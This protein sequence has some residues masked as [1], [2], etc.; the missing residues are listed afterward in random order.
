[1]D[2]HAAEEHGGA[3]A[4]RAARIDRPVMLVIVMRVVS[5]AVLVRH[6]LVLVFVLMALADVQPH[7]ERPASTSS[8]RRRLRA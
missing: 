3:N 2:V 4:V 8:K 5:V 6:L 1:V 7:A